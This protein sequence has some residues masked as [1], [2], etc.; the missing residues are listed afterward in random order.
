V[1]LD[2]VRVTWFVSY[3]PACRLWWYGFAWWVRPLLENCIVDASIFEIFQDCDRK[4]VGPWAFG[5]VVPCFVVILVS[6]IVVLPEVFKGTLVDALALGAE[7]G[8]CSL[9]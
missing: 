4:T 6:V 3:P 7:E 9:R 8:R 2:R 1:F 5:F